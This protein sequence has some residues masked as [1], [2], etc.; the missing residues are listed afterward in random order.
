MHKNPLISVVVPTFNRAHLIEHTLQSLLRQTWTDYEIIVVDDGSSD[1]T[2]C[3]VKKIGNLRIR[4][5]NKENAE[6]AAAR[7]YGVQKAQGDYINF[8]DSDDLALSNHLYEAVKMIE[9]KSSPEWFHLG[10][11]VVNKFC[12]VICEINSF[13]GDTLQKYIPYGNRLSANGVFIRKDIALMHPFNEER[14]LSA[15]EDYELWYRLAA[16]Y[17]LYYSNIIT[18]H[19]V[20]HEDR[21]INKLNGQYLI[22]RINILLDSLRNDV[23]VQKVFKNIFFDTESC[24]AIH[25]ALHLSVESQW[26]WR[27]LNEL[28]KGILLSPKSIINR[29]VYAVIRNLLFRWD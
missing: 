9:S 26:K 15:S 24:M 27:A 13:S 3:E 19:V 21:S 12:E 11:A 7:N 1:N 17:P 6:R 25:L 20:E 18:S 28:I 23:E 2:E 10:F 16:R 14:K 4:Y 22:D 8:F 29:Q 5:F